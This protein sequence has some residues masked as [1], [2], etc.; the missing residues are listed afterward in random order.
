MAPAL[1]AKHDG[2]WSLRIVDLVAA[3]EA[4]DGLAVGRRV[5]HEA[6]DLCGVPSVARPLLARCSQIKGHA[7][8]QLAAAHRAQAVQLIPVRGIQAPE[9]VVICVCARLVT[10]AVHE[11]VVA[12][13]AEA[14]D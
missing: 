14:H 11:E 13:A 4:P 6:L 7:E 12:A 2:T 1:A 9:R 10:H 5:A 8:Q 3:F